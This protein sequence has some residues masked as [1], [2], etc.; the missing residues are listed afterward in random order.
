MQKENIFVIFVSYSFKT[1]NVL[2]ELYRCFF[3]FRV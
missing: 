2:D 3:K 1:N